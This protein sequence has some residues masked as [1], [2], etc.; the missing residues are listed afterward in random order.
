MF[1]PPF[2]GTHISMK[3]KEGSIIM[4]EKASYFVLMMYLKQQE[5]VETWS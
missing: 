3:Q 1:G 4:E 5:C 2:Y